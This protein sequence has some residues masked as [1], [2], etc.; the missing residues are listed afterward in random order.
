[1]SQVIDGY[2]VDLTVRKLGKNEC[3]RDGPNVTKGKLCE[4]VDIRGM[5]PGEMLR[6][7][8]FGDINYTLPAFYITLE[9]EL[10]Q[11]LWIYKKEPSE[12]NRDKVVF[13]LEM[14]KKEST[15]IYN[16][17]KYNFEPENE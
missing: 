17:S 12:A 16:R 11:A 3:Q 13:L 7:G 4:T 2:K 8:A 10:R 6:S 15:I 5:S 9:H 1:M 14:A